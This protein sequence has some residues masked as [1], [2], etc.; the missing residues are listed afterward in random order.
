MIETGLKELDKFLD[1][2]IK[3]GL[4]T[5]ISGQSAT[6]KSHSSKC[7]QPKP[8]SINNFTLGPSQA[9]IFLTRWA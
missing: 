2:G 7:Y 8:I 6:G 9:K 4:I 3:D 5:S 1:G